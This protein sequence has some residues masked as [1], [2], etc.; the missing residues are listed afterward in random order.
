VLAVT[1]A[2]GETIMALTADVG[3]QANGGLRISVDSAHATEQGAAMAVAVVTGSEGGDEV[4][5][6][7]RGAHV[8]LEPGVASYLTDRVLDV[9]NQPDGRIRF[10]VHGE[11]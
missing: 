7:E 2:A 5:T 6:A 11:T 3:E 4:V 8:F 9:E 1:E 10:A